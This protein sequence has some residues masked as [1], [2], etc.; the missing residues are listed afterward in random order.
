MKLVWVT[1]GIFT[2]MA[3]P[4]R[5]EKSTPAAPA[6]DRAAQP[7]PIVLVGLMARALPWEDASFTTDQDTSAPP[8]WAMPLT[9]APSYR[10]GLVRSLAASA[11]AI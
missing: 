10:T 9:L 3:I 5:A 7:L 1:S 6:R 11:A 2:Y 8:L 4:D